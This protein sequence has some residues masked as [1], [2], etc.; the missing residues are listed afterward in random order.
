MPSNR[1]G[2]VIVDHGSGQLKIR[3]S[4]VRFRPWPP[5]RISYLRCTPPPADARGAHLVPTFGRHDIH[6]WAYAGDLAPDFSQP[7]KPTD[8]A[9]IEA[10]N[11]RVQQECLNQHWFPSVEN[12]RSKSSNGE[13]NT[14]PSDPVACSAI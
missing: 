2:P 9:F 1:S 4:V 10:F 13:T 12:A 8:N 5:F 6:L 14:T 3:V 11:A 7:G